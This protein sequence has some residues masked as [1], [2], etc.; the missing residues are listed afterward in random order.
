M[1]DLNIDLPKDFLLEEVRSGYMVSSKMK[2]VWAIQLDLLSELLRVCN[3]NGLKV[4]ADSGTL[5]GSVRHKGYI[6]WD[7]DIDVYLIRDDYDRLCGLSHEFREGY[8]LQNMT[9]DTIERCHSQL[10]RNGTAA[11][12]KSD[13]GKSFNRGIFID[14]FVLD[15]VPNDSNEADRFAY[16]IGKRYRAFCAPAR[17]TYYKS[18]NVIK[19]IVKVA[20]NSFV[21]PIMNCFY[22]KRYNCF[23]KKSKAFSE[24]N[25]FVAKYNHN[26]DY[27]CNISCYGTA[28]KKAIY[29]EKELYLDLVQ[30]DF[31]MF[32]LYAPKDYD[33]RLRM[34]Y[35]DYMVFKIGS[36][37]HGEVFFDV[38]KSYKEYDC[39]TKKEFSQLFNHDSK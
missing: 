10:R 23:D 37:I 28:N 8:F 15:Y 12:L 9:T 32:K 27:V 6:P 16:E 38:N 14:I 11:L 30:L 4:I 13:Y 19:R 5:L 26:T 33:K 21:F 18:D 29:Y 7:D 24:W 2:Q 39:L 34:E 22:N 1:V 25:S 17:K 31:E 3:D 20:W 35:G 36:S